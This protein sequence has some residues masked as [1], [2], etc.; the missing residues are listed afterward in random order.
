MKD[1]NYN[2]MIHCG[3]NPGKKTISYRFSLPCFVGSLN[4]I[5]WTCASTWV[6]PVFSMVSMHI[7]Q[8]SVGCFSPRLL[9]FVFNV[10][11]YNYLGHT[12]LWLSYTF[13]QIL[14]RDTYRYFRLDKLLKVLSWIT[15][16]LLWFNRL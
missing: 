1:K 3:L 12:F 9:L 4:G 13:V 16:M 10:I 2:T 14:F 6:N 15:L 11:P 7:F 8:L 5:K